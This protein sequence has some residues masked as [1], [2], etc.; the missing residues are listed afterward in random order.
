MY[1]EISPNIKNIIEINVKR[2]LRFN[3]EGVWTLEKYLIGQF[4][5]YE[6][7]E[8]IEQEYLEKRQEALYKLT[9][10]KICNLCNFKS[11]FYEF[12][13]YYYELYD[14]T[15]N[16]ETY[17]QLLLNKFPNPTIDTF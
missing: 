1:I 10:L 2:K 12:N 4:E 7:I 11:F 3:I 5:G 8:N 13:K 16:Q 6:Y 14:S 17:I 15:E 9:N